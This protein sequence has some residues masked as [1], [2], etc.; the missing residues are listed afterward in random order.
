MAAA[1]SASG[2]AAMAATAGIRTVRLFVFEDGPRAAPRGLDLGEIWGEHAV[3]RIQRAAWHPWRDARFWRQAAAQV[4]A[5][6]A[7]QL[8]GRDLAQVCLAFRRIE[9]SSL[10]LCACCE[11]EVEE[12][13]QRFNIFELAAVA[14]YAASAQG[15]ASTAHDL[16]VR[17]A[18]EACL[19]WRQRELVPWSAWRMLVSGAAGTGAAHQ[20][21][22]KVAAP[23]LSKSVPQMSSRDAVDICAAYAAFRFKHHALLSELSRFLPSMGLTDREVSALQ[24]SFERLDFESL[25][26]Q[27]LKEL[28]SFGAGAGTPWTA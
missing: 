1:A 18:D 3:R 20:E 7:G 4:A 23:H 14:L 10:E 2:A 16:V 8:S 17:I 6:P 12:R 13:R 19:E 15:S 11:R 28:R 25:P 24:G 21:L 5:V 22:F 9:F 27:R 26:L